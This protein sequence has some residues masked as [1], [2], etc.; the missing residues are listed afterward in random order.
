MDLGGTKILI[1]LEDAEGNIL[2]SRKFTVSAEKGPAG[3]LQDLL[4]RLTEFFRLDRKD[5]EG[6]GFCLAGYYDKGKEIMLGSPN[7]P[8]WENYPILRRLRDLFECPVVVENDANAAAWGEYRY[9][10]GKGAKNILM[11]TLG[12]GVGCALIEDG[13]LVHGERGL[14]GEI[15]H[16]PLLPRGGPLCGC[17]N[18]GCLESL[19][20][21]KAIAR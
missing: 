12:T 5:I 4:M 7:L 19:A 9:G 10:A 15:G 8:G 20:S 21:G 17:G 18:T 14:A 6:L 2:Q 11:V 16:L 1:A 13:R 3:I